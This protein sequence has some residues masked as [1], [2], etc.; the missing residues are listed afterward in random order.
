[1]AGIFRGC[2]ETCRP[3]GGLFSRRSLR[4]LRRSRPAEV[5]SIGRAS[6]RTGFKSRPIRV[7]SLSITLRPHPSSLPRERGADPVPDIRHLIP[8]FTLYRISWWRRSA[9]SRAAF[10]RYPAGCRDFLDLRHGVIHAE[11][12]SQRSV[13]LLVL[14]TESHQHVRGVQ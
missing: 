12:H 4:L 9:T 11:S 1:M 2:P 14:E 5:A 7:L 6:V 3:Y 8:A 13:S 10:E